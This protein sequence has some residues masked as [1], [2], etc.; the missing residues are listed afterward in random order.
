M[1]D[2]LR[3]EPVATAT[4]TVGDDAVHA[5]PTLDTDGY[6]VL[7][8]FLDPGECERLV[9]ITARCGDARAGSRRLLQHPAIA[10]I[11]ARIRALPQLAG[12]LPDDAVVVQCTLFAKT[13]DGNWS[14]T[15]HQDLSI[16]VDECI[17][18]PECTGWSRK[19][20]MLFVQPP[21]SVLETLLAIRLQLDDRAEDTGPLEVVPGSHRL[22]RL[23]CTDVA[24][25]ASGRRVVCV[26]QR[27]GAVA[28]RP[29]T[30]HASSKSNSPRPRRVLH[31]LFGPRQLPLGL[32]WATAP[33]A[34]AST[35]V[36]R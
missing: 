16:P 21:T 35:R 13:K 18:S 1:H 10:G 19:E 24:G 22:G 9:D 33:Q 14:V 5:P 15:P 23:K 3:R 8:P 36:S 17:D 2:S 29:L 11:A 31:F 4:E 28:L 7:A 32:R 6:V 25:H 20:S 27:G 26:P 12:L 30:I 34:G